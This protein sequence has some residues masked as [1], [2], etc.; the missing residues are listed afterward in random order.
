MQSRRYLGFSYCF[1]LS[2]RISLRYRINLT[3]SFA[4]R[5]SKDMEVLNINAGLFLLP[6]VWASSWELGGKEGDSSLGAECLVRGK[7][8]LIKCEKWL[9]ILAYS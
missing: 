4:H 8:R 9:K 6:G 5:P 7:Q 3:F 2:R 1:L